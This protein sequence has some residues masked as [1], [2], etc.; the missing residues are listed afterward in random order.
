MSSILLGSKQP[1]VQVIPTLS[2]QGPLR[3]QFHTL[4]TTN[5]SHQCWSKALR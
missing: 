1:W 2:G 5:E 4:V 3:L